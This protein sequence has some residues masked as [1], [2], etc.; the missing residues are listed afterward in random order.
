VPLV[1]GGTEPSVAF[2]STRA[3]W[4]M[5]YATPLSSDVSVRSGLGVTGPW[6][7]PHTLGRCVLPASDPSSFCGE[8]A[9]VPEL[10]QNGDIAFTQAVASF[11]R[12][13]AATDSD[14]WTRL[15]RAPWPGELP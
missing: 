13:K 14:F 9:L 12:P 2:D 4:L 8:L 1:E 10:A 15:V 6:S 5:L 11:S 3:R 7:A